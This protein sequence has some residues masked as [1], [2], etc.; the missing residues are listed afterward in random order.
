MVVAGSAIALTVWMNRQNSDDGKQ[1]PSN[2]QKLGT[3]NDNSHDPGSLLATNSHAQAAQNNPSAGN[4]NGVGQATYLRSCA[5][6][7]GQ[8]GQGMPH[9]GPDLR[10][11]L[12]VARKSDQELIA[13]VK[14]GRMP[15]HP[16]SQMK[17]Y[18][19]PLG[20][21]PSL[22]DQDL[23][24]IIAHLRTLQSNSKLLSQAH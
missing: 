2:S 23:S 18:M 4:A 8:Q 3:S 6:C 17:L 9:Q 10:S 21:N 22:N 16:D 13:F 5:T 19:P 1:I 24:Q 12:F 7:H 14:T 11:S 15:N 20:G